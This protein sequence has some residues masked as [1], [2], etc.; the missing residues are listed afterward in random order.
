MPFLKQNAT[1]LRAAAAPS[2]RDQALAAG[3][4]DASDMLDVTEPAD[5]FAPMESASYFDPADLL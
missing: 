1:T 3:S 2:A 5:D 4:F